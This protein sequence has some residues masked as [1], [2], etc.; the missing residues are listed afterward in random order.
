MQIANYEMIIGDFFLK[1]ILTFKKEHFFLIL[2]IFSDSA[3][4]DLVGVATRDITDAYFMSEP[5]SMDKFGDQ[6]YFTK[7]EVSIHMQQLFETFL[8]QHEIEKPKQ[9]DDMK[10][11]KPARYIGVY[12]NN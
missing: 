5:A 6:F 1:G 8:E 11:F 9:L 7:D 2:K 4:T 12:I 3:N 10:M